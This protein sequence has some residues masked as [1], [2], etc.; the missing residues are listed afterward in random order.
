ME[1][2]RLTKIVPEVAVIILEPAL[3]VIVMTSLISSQ[4]ITVN[5]FKS[6]R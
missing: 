5:K 1:L 2:T 4:S 3:G 6:P